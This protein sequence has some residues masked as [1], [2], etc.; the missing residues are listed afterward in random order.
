MEGGERGAVV[1]A[2]TMYDL[3]R[4]WYSTRMDRDWAP[5]SAHEAQAI[6]ASHGLTGDFWE[7]G[8]GDYS[9]PIQPEDS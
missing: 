4:D 9:T 7:F 5:P 2:Q 3:S 8:D 1:D 6:F